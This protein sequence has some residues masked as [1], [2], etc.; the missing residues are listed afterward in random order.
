MKITLHV[1]TEQYG[2]VGAEMET[3][4]NRIQGG[5]AASIKEN[6]EAIAEAFK[7]KPLNCL[8]EK[9]WK[10]FIERILQNEPN[11][12]NELEQCSPEQRK[13][14]NEIKKALARLEAREG[15]ELRDRNN[16]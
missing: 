8:P 13:I 7:P 9:E 2:F 11:H 10:R 14:I 16:E 12:I 6:Y 3:V 15:G 5:D 1:P 4:H